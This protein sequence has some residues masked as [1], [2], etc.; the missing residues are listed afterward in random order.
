MAAASYANSVRIANKEAK[1]RGLAPLP[2][3]DAA[4]IPADPAAGVP[5]PAPVEQAEVLDILN[6]P[7]AEPVEA[8]AA[9]RGRGRGGRGR[10]RGRNG[11]G[12]GRHEEGERVQLHSVTQTTAKK[13][14]RSYVQGCRCGG[15]GPHR[16]ELLVEF[17]ANRHADHKLLATR[18]REMI[19]LESMS[20]E[21]ARNVKGRVIGQ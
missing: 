10:G 13:P 16:K 2:G 17:S 19:I 6:V 3:V 20:Y 11:G 7:G 18:A 5:L 14:A 1:K 4:P 8:P 15:R 9:P 21:E 12:G